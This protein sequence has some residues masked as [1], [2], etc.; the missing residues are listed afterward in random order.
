M[1]DDR[2]LVHLH[3]PARLARDLGILTSWDCTATV[4]MSTSAQQCL[5]YKYTANGS[6]AGFFT[7]DG[8]RASLPGMSENKGGQTTIADDDCRQRSQTRRQ[9]RRLK[10]ESVQ[11][12]DTLRVRRL[13][14]QRT[15]GTIRTIVG[16][17]QQRAN[18]QRHRTNT[19]VNHT[20][21]A[22]PII[23]ARLGRTRLTYGNDN[24][25]GGR[26]LRP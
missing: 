10:D 8:S 13:Q 12:Y 2:L 19:I 1:H 9:H 24:A 11:S 5:V 26:L 16:R 7:G 18:E 4:R 6:L 14:L 23:H 15:E 22:A 17:K 20:N 21:L 25:M 3:N